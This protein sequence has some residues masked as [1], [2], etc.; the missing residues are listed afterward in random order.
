[1]LNQEMLSITQSI[2]VSGIGLLIVFLELTALAV[3]IKV[4]TGILSVF[5]KPETVPA[6]AA[7]GGDENDEDYAVVLAVMSAELSRQGIQHRVTSVREV[8]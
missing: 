1:M 8:K 6:A 5:G 4:F 3:A 2:I 7:S